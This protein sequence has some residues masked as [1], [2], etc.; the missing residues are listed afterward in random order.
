MIESTSERRWVIK[1]DGEYLDE[2]ERFGPLSNA[3][4][5]HFAPEDDAQEAGG[6]PVQIRITTIY[7]EIG[8]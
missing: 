4:I 8:N 5:R 3:D 1:K 6:I 7:E 2:F